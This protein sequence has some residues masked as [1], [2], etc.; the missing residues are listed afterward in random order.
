[1]DGSRCLKK[2]RSRQG[3]ANGG[4]IAHYCAIP[5][6]QPPFPLLPTILRNINIFF[7]TTPPFLLLNIKLY[8]YC[9]KILTISC[10]GQ[11]ATRP[12]TYSTMRFTSMPAVEWC[13][14]P[15][16]AG[17][18][19]PAAPR[20]S[21]GMRASHYRRTIP[22]ACSLYLRLPKPHIPA[23]RQVAGGGGGPG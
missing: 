18:T 17:Q 13:P 23:S 19:S 1:M 2:N 16:R 20:D 4:I 3:N 15:S 11:R 14:S 5:S 8:C 21:R 10:K 22:A 12:S 6:S 7:P 9:N